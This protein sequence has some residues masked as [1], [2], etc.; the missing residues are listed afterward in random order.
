MRRILKIVTKNWLLFSITI[1]AAFLR[2]FRFDQYATFLADQGRDAIIIKRI[3][4]LEHWPAIGAPTSIGQV[5]LGPF[6]YYFIAPWLAIFNFNPLGLA[7]GVAIFSILFLFLLFLITKRLFN[8]KAAY[9]ALFIGSFSYVLIQLSRF[10][11]NPNLLPLFSLLTLFFFLKALEN[12]KILYFVL[13]GAFLSFT[14]QLHYLG[15]SL[16]LPIAVLSFADLFKDKKNVF[17]KLLSYFISVLSFLF[18]T[19]PLIIF[20]LRHN[21]LNYK[22]LLG[23]FESRQGMG[24]NVLSSIVST[25]SELNFYLFNVRLNNLISI[26]ILIG[27]L[28]LLFFYIRQQKFYRSIFMV[29]FIGIIFVLSLYSGPKHPHYLGM[30]YPFYIVIIGFI[31]ADIKS[32]KFVGNAITFLFLLGFLSL[33]IYNYDFMFKTHQN[34][35]AHAQKVAQLL[36]KVIDVKKFS[37]AVQPDGWQEDSYLYFLELYGKR[38]VDRKKLEVGTE[39]F[40]VCGN[41]CDLYNTKSWNVTMFGKFNIVKNWSVDGVM[42]YKLI[43]KK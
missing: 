16:G 29:F 21:F 19:S 13:F 27:F 22:N 25:F 12:K 11:W 15:L 20:D 17:K 7:V 34:Q 30:I 37:F 14:M 8:E 6:Y 36:N 31:L 18:F 32:Y 42:V 28:L 24:S 33:N 26:T 35:I 43:H 38:P 41:S 10:S 23:L 4:T 39:M 3:V 2:F 5:Y 40:V 9:I 1:I